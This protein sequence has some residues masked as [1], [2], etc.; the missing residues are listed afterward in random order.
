M[1]APQH[2][3]TQNLEL[4]IPDFDATSMQEIR[5]IQRRERI[6]GVV[7]HIIL[8]NAHTVWEYWWYVPGRILLSED[9]ELLIR[10]R[11]R[12]EKIIENLVWFFG[13]HCFCLESLLSNTYTPI[14]RQIT[15]T[16]GFL[17]TWILP[18]YLD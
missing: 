15:I 5:E 8:L 7:K 13:G 18:N 11:S 9:I 3:L 17:D 14:K 6:S 12:L 4:P 16:G 1:L 2:P 10:D